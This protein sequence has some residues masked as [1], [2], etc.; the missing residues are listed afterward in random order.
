MIMNKK[1]KI[2]RESFLREKSTETPLKS[3]NH[4]LLS[5]SFLRKTNIEIP[6]KSLQHIMLSEIVF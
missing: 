6:L 2:V 3:L 5:A 1:K 4:I